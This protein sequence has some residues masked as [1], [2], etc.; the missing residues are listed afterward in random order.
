MNFIHDDFLLDTRESRRLYHDY[1]ENLPIIDYHCHLSPEAVATDRH[2][3][4]LTEIWLAGD[5]YK[6]RAMRACGVDERFITGDATE[7]EKFDRWAATVPGTLRNPLYHWTHL[8]LA[9]VF[10]IAGTLL[11]PATADKIW[12]ACNGVLGEPR[13]SARGIIRSMNVEVLCTVDD[14]VDS[15]E[16]HA[17]IRDEAEPGFRMLPTFR[18]DRALAVEQPEAFRAYARELAASTG[19]EI[20]S[21]GDFIGAL[22]L[23]HEFFH[24][25]GCRLSDHGLETVY[26]GAPQGVEAVFRRIMRGNAPSPAEAGGLKSALL[27]ELALMDHERG[28][29]QQ[30]HVGALRNVRSAMVRLRGADAGC[31]TIGDAPLAAPLARFLDALDAEGK[32]PRTIL[33]NLNPRDNELIAAMAGCFQDG[34]T[35]GKI[36]Y[37][38]A[39][40]FL[41]TEGGIVR[42]IDALSALGILGQFVGMVTDSRSFL[43]YPRHEYF[44]RVLCNV[45]GHDMARGV[46]PHDMALVGNLVQDVC[47]RNAR[48]WFRFPGTESP[49]ETRT[50]G[51]AHR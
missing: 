31:D 35:A 44:R 16:F 13:L 6:W 26:A 40:W 19:T 32:L 41:D 27:G 14:P 43:S 4:S 20:R 21:L 29:A 33:F 39:W 5:H 15:L 46:I 10:G 36:Q 17:R 28:W 51:E 24:S 18:P 45:L 1:A 8:E 2:F 23:R 3:R 12:E 49:A 48:R 42:Q 22:R 50:A 30:I 11:G 7:R 47:Y 34:L 38:P 9:R 25:M 37:G